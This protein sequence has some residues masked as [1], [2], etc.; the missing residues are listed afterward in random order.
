M[1][2]FAALSTL[3][4][5][6]LHEAGDLCGVR[7]DSA[8]QWATGRR[9]APPGAIDRLRDLIATQERVATQTLAQIVALAQQHGAPAE[10]EIGYP[11][12]DYEAQSLGFPCVGAWAA[13]AARVIAAAPVSVVLTPRGSTVA[14][15]AAVAAPGS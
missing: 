13:M 3:A 1:T 5:L 6:T 12:D 11:A 9:T 7:H 14:P 10:I 2:P 4:G 8:R 15:A